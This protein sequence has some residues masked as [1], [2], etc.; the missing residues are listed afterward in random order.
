MKRKCFACRRHIDDSSTF[1]VD[2]VTAKVASAGA[3]FCLD[4]VPPQQ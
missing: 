2:P 4:C 3:A 1:Y